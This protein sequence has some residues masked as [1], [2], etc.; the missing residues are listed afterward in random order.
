MAFSFPY[1]VSFL[2]QC[3]AGETIPLGLRRFDEM[4]GSGDGRMWGLQVATPLWGASYGLY[5]KHGAKAREINAKIYGLD[6]MSKTMLW[7][8]PYYK[9]PASG[10]VAG[11]GAVTVSGIRADRGGI[12][13][14]GL[15]EGF[16]LTPGDY[17][18][19]Q[20]GTG[21]VYFGT[22]G[23]GGTAG[24]AGNISAAR[25]IRPYLPFGVSVGATVELVRPYF[26]AMVTDFTPFA[27]FR[28]R[29]GESASITIMQKP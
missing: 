16:T 19:I 21:R 17:F 26:K 23:E 25:E 5:S 28:G 22:F 3:L 10:Q 11:L 6:G 2:A 14:S 15:P 4:S 20:Y 1:E 7:A 12:G 9:G 27:N 29:W 24:A 13:L 8:D 18:S